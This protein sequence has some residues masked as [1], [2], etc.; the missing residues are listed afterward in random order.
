MST[1]ISFTAD[2]QLKE[3]A[4]KKATEEG[5]TLK[6]L[7]IYAMK[8]FVDGKLSFSLNAPDKTLEVEELHFADKTLE[9]KAKKLAKLLR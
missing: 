1:Q 3:K 2:K 9:I 6:A 5:I 7:L 4:L 8:G